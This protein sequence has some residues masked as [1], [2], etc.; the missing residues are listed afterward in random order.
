LNQ[1]IPIYPDLEGK[2]AVVTGGSGDIGAVTC[3][4]LA[5]NG[6]K[7]AVNGRDA[8]KIEAVVAWQAF[9]RRQSHRRAHRPGAARA[10]R[11]PPL[12]GRSE[13][14]SPGRGQAA[15]GELVKGS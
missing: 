9:G 15:V 7:V 1:R 3:R 8:E 2:V 5:A 6:A 10:G 11:H 13:G 4:L 14:N 12:P